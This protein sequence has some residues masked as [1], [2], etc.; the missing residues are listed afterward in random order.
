MAGVDQDGAT[1]KKGKLLNKGRMVV[2][3]GIEEWLV[4]PMRIENGARGGLTPGPAR[5]RRSALN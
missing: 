1:T 5:G 3:S 2:E 4:T